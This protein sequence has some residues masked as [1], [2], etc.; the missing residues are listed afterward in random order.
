[1]RLCDSAGNARNIRTQKNNKSGLKGVYWA[2][3]RSKWRAEITVDRQKIHI[4]SFDSPG[5]A[6][7]AYDKYALRYFGEFAKTNAMLGNYSA[8][9]LTG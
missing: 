3:D 1:M 7:R 2:S 4:G 9:E 5:E 8:V 6:A